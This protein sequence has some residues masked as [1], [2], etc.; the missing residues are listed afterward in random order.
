MSGSRADPQ[1]LAVSGRFVGFYWTL[2]IPAVGFTRLPKA[3]DDAARASRTIRYQRERIRRWVESEKGVLLAEFAFLELKPDRGSDMIAGELA[4]ALRTA[5][6]TAATFVYVHFADYHQARLHPFMQSIL[7]VTSVPCMALSP[8]PEHVGHDSFD[9][10]EHFR[11][12]RQTLPR[13]RGPDRQAAILAAVAAALEAVGNA[14]GKAERIAE[15]LNAHSVRT[16]NGRTWTG[17][18]V[19]AFLHKHGL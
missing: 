5:E 10:I 19:R 13:A 3:V 12:S 9:P 6:N 15:R 1:G 17:A 4:K 8:D 7:Q 18:N 2:P 11:S 14:P 16:A